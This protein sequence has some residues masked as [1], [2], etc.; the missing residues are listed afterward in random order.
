L[1]G[2]VEFEVVGE[3]VGLVGLDDGGSEHGGV[4]AGWVEGLGMG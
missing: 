2:E 3:G 4:L 1:G